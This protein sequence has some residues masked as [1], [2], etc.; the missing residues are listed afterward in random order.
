MRDYE[1]RDLRL[2]ML[3]PIM[4]IIAVLFVIRLLYELIMWVSKFF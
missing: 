3:K 4:P 2:R 1:P